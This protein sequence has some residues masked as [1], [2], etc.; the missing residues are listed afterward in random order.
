MDI[1][2]TDCFAVI[3]HDL[4]K[5]GIII[6]QLFEMRNT[7]IEIMKIE[8]LKRIISGLSETLTVNEIEEGIIW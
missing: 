1:F 6:L 8:R 3:E 2:L 4:H 5:P 7:D